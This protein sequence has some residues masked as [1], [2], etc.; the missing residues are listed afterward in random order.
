MI[1]NSRKENLD[2]NGN[3]NFMN[4][5]VLKEI[6]TYLFLKFKIYFMNYLLLNQKVNF[7]HFLKYCYFMNIIFLKET[8]TYLFLKVQIYFMNYLLLN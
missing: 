6:V 5:I 1:I 7:H 4:V 3:N 8:V 2:E